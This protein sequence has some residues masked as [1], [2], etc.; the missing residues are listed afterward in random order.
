MRCG[1]VDLERT[2]SVYV[3]QEHDVCI[4]DLFVMR[5]ACAGSGCAGGVDTNTLR[6][7]VCVCASVRKIPRNEEGTK[8]DYLR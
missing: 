5:P 2:H 6:V 1:D 3:A 7:C 4:K 8:N